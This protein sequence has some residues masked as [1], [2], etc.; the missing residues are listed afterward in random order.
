MG[1]VTSVWVIALLAGKLVFALAAGT[2][3]AP[4][5]TAGVTLTFAGIVAAVAALRFAHGSSLD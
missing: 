5:G 3:A 4:W 2:L 1:S